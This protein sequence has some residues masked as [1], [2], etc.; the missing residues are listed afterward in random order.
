[1]EVASSAYY[2]WDNLY[3]DYFLTVV[4]HYVMFEGFIYVAYAGDSVKY[5]GVRGILTLYEL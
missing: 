2:Y 5:V 4:S 3:F 1:M